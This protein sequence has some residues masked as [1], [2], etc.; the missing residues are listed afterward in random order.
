M[1]LHN[2]A[3]KAV[4]VPAIIELLAQRFP[5]S[6][7]AGLGEIDEAHARKFL[8]QVAFRHGDTNSGGTFFKLIESERGIEAFMLGALYRAYGI[9]NR[10]VAQDMML[11]GRED[12]DPHAM[13]MLVDDYITWARSSPKCI[14]IQLTWN[15]VL[16][17]SE[18]L[19]AVY[20]RKGFTQCGEVYRC[21]M[22][23][24]IQEAA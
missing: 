20:R 2:R 4:D 14:E 15:D 16:P 11:L 1:L 6:R 5:Q 19:A 8:A 9:G 22:P 7:Y 12:C 18:R 23:Q 3:A 10:L 24:T 13:A 17:S 21:T